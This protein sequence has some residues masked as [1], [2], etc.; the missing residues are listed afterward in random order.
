MAAVSSPLLIPGCQLWL[1]A[2]DSSTLFDATVGGSL[3]TTDGT[4]VARWEDKSGNGRHATQSTANARPLLRTNVKNGR[5]V[6]R[7]DGSNDFISGSSFPSVS[8]YSIF[9]VYKRTGSN[10]NAFGNFTFV[11]GIGK[12]GDGTAA[13]R[14]THI[15]YASTPNAFW[16]SVRVGAADLSITRNDNFNVHSCIAPLGTGTARYLLNGSNEQTVDVSTLNG[17]TNTPLIYN[18]GANTWNQGQFMNGDISEI[19]VYNTALTTTQRQSVEGYLMDKWGIPL[20][21]N[22]PNDVVG[23]QLWLDASDTSTL[24]MATSAVRTNL[25]T[26]SEDFDNTANWSVN[27]ITSRTANITASPFGLMTAD[28]ITENTSA[29]AH[30]IFQSRNTYPAGVYTASVYL[31]Y[32]SKQFAS[33]NIYSGTTSATRVGVTLDLT[34]GTVTQ[35]NTLGTPGLSS[36]SVDTTYASQGWYRVTATMQCSAVGNNTGIAINLSNTGTPTSF[37]ASTLDPSYTGTSGAMFIY[38][39]QFEAGS[40]ATPYLYSGPVSNSV[41]RPLSGKNVTN[42]LTFSEDWGN[43]VWVKDNLTVA[44]NVSASPIGTLSA[45]KLFETVT[46]S[47]VAHRVLNQFNSAAQHIPITFSVYAKQAERQFVQLAV[48]AGSNSNIFTTIFDITSGAGAVAASRVTGT[49]SLSTSTITHVGSGWYRCSI[50]GTNSNTS[51]TGNIFPY[52]NITDRPDFTGTLASTVY[53]AYIGSSLSG[54]LVWGAQLE[55]GS[56]STYVSTG[57]STVTALITSDPLIDNSLIAHWSNKSVNSSVSSISDFTDVG[58]SVVT[59]PVYK[60]NIQN[61]YGVVRFNGISQYLTD[62]FNGTNYTSQTVFVVA[63][64][65]TSTGG[66]DRY[67]TQNSSAVADYTIGSGHY[68]PIIRNTTTQTVGSYANGIAVSTFTPRG[69]VVADIMTST[70]TGSAIQCFLNGYPSSSTYAHSLN[71]NVVMSRLGANFDSTIGSYLRGGIAEVIVYNQCLSLTERQAVENYLA[72]KWNLPRTVR[73]LQDGNWYDPNT[74]SINAESSS[75]NVPASTDDVFA[76]SFNINISS[77]VIAQSLNTLNTLNTL[78]LTGAL[79]SAAFLSGGTFNITQPI[80]V[81]TLS[82]IRAGSTTCIVDHVSSGTVSFTGNVFAG[83]FTNADGIINLSG[84]NISV[85]GNITGGAGI[86]ADGLLNPFGGN[87]SVTGNVTGGSNTNANGINS[88]SSNNISVTGNVTGGSNSTAYGILNNQSTTAIISGNILGG[89]GTGVWSG[90]LGNTLITGNVTGGSG[91]SAFGAVNNST[92]SI[93]ILGNVTGG[94]SGSGAVNNSTGSISIT[95]VTLAGSAAS[96]S[97]AVNNGAGNVTLVG[98]VSGTSA[99]TGAHNNGFGNIYVIGDIRP[100]AGTSASVG[101]HNASQGNAYITGNV[102][103][104]TIASNNSAVANSSTGAVL[105]VG[106][107]FGSTGNTQ[108]INNSSTGTLLISGIITAS[109]SMHGV[110]SSNT[111]ARNIFTGSLVNGLSGRQAVYAARYLLRPQM[112]N[113]YTRIAGPSAT[114][115]PVFYYGP[116]AY[117]STYVPHTSSVRAGTTYAA[118]SSLSEV[119]VN[120]PTQLIGTMHVPSPASVSF[121]VPVESTTGTGIVSPASLQQLWSVSLDNIKTSNSLGARL[122]NVATIQEV[123]DLLAYGVTSHNN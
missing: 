23:C 85:F 27:G 91:T 4:A 120:I 84:G 11:F 22:S 82:G 111:A 123:G 36:F 49:A 100:G 56:L 54:V 45:D 113:S 95:G 59:R 26:Y 12:S 2:A 74:W 110:V 87:I 98:N 58:G 14:L 68:I 17:S 115:T 37:V 77:S 42:L 20:A 116:E 112:F 1:D 51:T 71:Y 24:A 104:G 25:L 93:S 64:L 32:H 55:Y 90:S 28:L 105:I 13:G 41:F 61:N 5:N 70:H 78:S 38:G 21:I 121:N 16:W 75:F 88:L 6:L 8:Q 62:Y 99:S 86:G 50:T 79:L 107:V 60:T 18:L 72:R 48:E 109:E 7:F 66:W 35:V 3:V 76:N 83:N 46:A 63:T 117:A 122:K 15:H 69:T 92:G 73:A 31:K 94:S 96:A 103:G 33:V 114:N 106:N 118:V 108:A 97:G 19:L 81:V 47:P 44:A 102:I 10:T 43:G 39:A 101:L 67:Y 57:A 53:P 119:A 52:I 30:G 40:V 9:A 80:N 29:G 89:T 65:G 34:T